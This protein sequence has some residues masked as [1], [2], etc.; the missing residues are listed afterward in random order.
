MFQY[1]T[2]PKGRCL[3]FWFYITGLDAGFLSFQVVDK[4]SDS[5]TI[6]WNKGGESL[7]DQWNFGSFGFYVENP[8]FIR[9]IGFSGGAPGSVAL[10]DLMFQDS[11]FCAT[12]PDTAG[13][14]SGL[15]VPVTTTVKP[16]NAN[17]TSE[18]DCDFESG[19]CNWQNSGR[20]GMLWK[21]IRGSQYGE[22]GPEV[23]HTLGTALGYYINIGMKINK[24]LFSIIFIYY[25]D[26][27]F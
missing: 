7:G 8:Y 15:P 13:K 14:G 20:N 11:T 21:R 4:V 6:V 24:I 5:Y 1:S 22:T 3:S 12:I 25:L 26:T 9:I 17:Q 19:L 16:P 10:D 2:G 23:D 27:F 18:Y